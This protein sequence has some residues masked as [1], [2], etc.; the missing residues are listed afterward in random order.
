MQ[1]E[2]LSSSY[3]YKDNWFTA[4]RDRCKTPGGKIVDPYYVLEFPDWV[5]GVAFTKEGQIIM[6]RQY[7]HALGRTL[8]EIPGGCIDPDDPDPEFAMRRELLEETGFSFEKI[9]ALGTISPNPSTNSNI[10]YMFLAEGGEK[11]QEQ[12][13]D[14]NEEIEVLFYSPEKVI[15]LLGENQILQSL[16]ATCLFYAFQHL[17][18]LE[19]K[20]QSPKSEVR[21]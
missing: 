18:W 1:W 6:I 2:T 9:T 20:Y 17:G 12:K 15:Q 19:M 13:L 7:R 10:T 4:R 21:R 3:V 16:H 5:N 11:I 14:P 8:L